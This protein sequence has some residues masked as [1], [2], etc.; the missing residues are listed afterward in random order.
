MKTLKRCEWPAGDAVMLRY[1][2]EEWGVPVHDDW[3]Q[4]EYAHRQAAGLVNDHLV[5]CFR[6]RQLAQLARKRW[7]RVTTGV[8]LLCLIGVVASASGTAAEEPPPA[9]DQTT[10]TFDTDHTGAAPA[11]FSFGRTGRG[12]PG[13]W[14]VQSAPDAPSGQNVLAQVDADHTDYRFPMAV[15]LA[16]TLRNL[17]VAVKCKPVAGE[18]DQACGLVFRYQDENNYYVT[19]ANALEGNVR[20][21]RV[22]KGNRQQFASWNGA[23]A[24]GAWHE[25]AAE[26]RGDHFTVYWDGQE[27]MAADDQTF[28]E[29]GKVG[30][31][32]KADSVTYF[33]NLRVEPLGP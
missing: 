11:G 21:Y 32:T 19:R 14:I 12:A 22:V 8:V 5:H 16:P 33:D 26:A 25:L 31:W 2:D 6:H 3:K 18:V 4:F 13:R 20:L 17:R 27:I 29:P 7:C 28:R 1:H 15:A 10:W 23:V 9:A 24:T 30:V